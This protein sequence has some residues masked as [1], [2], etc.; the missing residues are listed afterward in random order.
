[1]QYTIKIQIDEFL[2]INLLNKKV[3]TLQ[4]LVFPL[5]LSFLAGK[6]DGIMQKKEQYIKKVKMAVT[7]QHTKT[8]HY[9][10]ERNGAKFI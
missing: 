9:S 5:S 3:C 6:K 7:N 4:V 2:Y 10:S 8:K 1:M